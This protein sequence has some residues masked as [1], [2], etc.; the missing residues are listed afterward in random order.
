MSN[1]GNGST[2]GDT[3]GNGD[4][5]NDAGFG[6]GIG[7]GVGNSAF[8]GLFPKI[9]QLI[10]NGNQF[11]A[12]DDIQ[13]VEYVWTDF[14]DKLRSKTRV[15]EYNESYLSDPSTLPDW[16]YDG[17]STKQ[18]NGN[19]SEIMI[20]PQKV[21]KCPFRRGNNLIVLCDGY[22]PAGEAIPTNHR[23]QANEIFENPTVKAC[24]PWYGLE[25]EFYFRT[26]K[27]DRI[28]GFDNNTLTNPQRQGSY[29]CSIGAKNAFGRN[30]MEDTL[31][32]FVFAGLD[33]S[34]INAEV[35]PGQWEFQIGPV[36]GIDAGDQMYLARYI[37]ER[38]AEYY[39]VTIDYHPKP[40]EGTEWNGSGCHINFSTEDMRNEGALAKIHEAIEKL[41]SAHDEHMAVYG[42]DNDQR[43]TGNNETSRYDE[44][45]FGVADRGASIRIPTHVN[46]FGAGYLEDRRPA[47]N[48][49]PYCAI[50]IM[51]QTICLPD[52]EVSH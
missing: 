8:G 51:A 26:F 43:L 46:T 47:S 49:E 10:G 24:K 29:Y 32:R 1:T 19:D 41:E 48:I 4:T 42:R 37:L 27:T 16:N 36:E 21:I 35:G 22:T 7:S 45:T 13:V 44:F 3:G 23:H 25:Q 18:A 38:T 9:N 15:L 11:I 14:E 2:G 28:L 5:I 33:V 17:S 12:N 40:L 20:K 34:G 39:G 52:E 31:E 6:G 30:I 50:G